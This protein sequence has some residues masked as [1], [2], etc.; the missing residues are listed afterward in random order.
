MG[1]HTNSNYER[2]NLQSSIIHYEYDAKNPHGVDSRMTLMG[3]NG[4]TPSYFIASEGTVGSVNLAYT[5]PIQDMGKLKAIRFYNDY[6]Y[7]D[8]TESDWKASQ[9]NTTGAMF[10]AKPFMV[11][12]DYTWAKNANI[13]GG[14]QN[15]TGLTTGQDSKYSDQW[16]YR[17]NLNLGVSF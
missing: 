13:L 11:W 3:A 7:F 2:W 5:L 9:M 10:I 15:G 16:L 6:S 8:K 14:A 17:V 1:V 12:A 4:L